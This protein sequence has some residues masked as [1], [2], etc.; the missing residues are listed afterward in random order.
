MPKRIKRERS[1]GWK[2]PAGAV[3][4]GRPSDFGNPFSGPRA[5]H[6]YRRWLSGKMG[7]AE[8]YKLRSDTWSLHFDRRRI[9]RRLDELRGRDLAC[10]C[11]LDA[12]CH[13]DVLIELAN[14]AD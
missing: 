7:R 10:W 5:A 13:A 1:K 12:E 9:V 6:R 8:F 11:D 3:Y 2:M 14:P 4:V